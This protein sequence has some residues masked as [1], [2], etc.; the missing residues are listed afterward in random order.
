MAQKVELFLPTG[1]FKRANT[2]SRL[3]PGLVRHLS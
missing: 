1:M 2:L 3:A